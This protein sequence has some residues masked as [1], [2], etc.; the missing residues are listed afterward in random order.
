MANHLNNEQL[1]KEK[2]AL[3]L[4]AAG[5][6]IREKGYHRARMAD[7]ARRAGI[8]YGLV[9]HYFGGKA[10]VL[11]ALIEEW[12]N[13]LDAVM[14]LQT[15]GDRSV[16]KRL[17]A[18]VHFFLDQYEGRPDLVHVIITEVSRSTIHLT[19]ERL[20]HIKRIMARTEEI[21]VRGQEEHTLRRDL[22][23]R[24]LSYFFLG[25]V[26][27]LLSTMV[28][29]GQALSG[30]AQKQRLAEALLTMFFDGARAR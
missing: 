16:E 5:R 4:E 9:Y 10:E 7:I 13:G 3:I 2:Q 17:E 12:F 19:P 21:M 26:E 23:A 11:D 27:T 8:S 30:R 15:Q 6:V 18:L 1:K 20:S 29:E 28:Y 22:K 25:A 14:D 24:Y